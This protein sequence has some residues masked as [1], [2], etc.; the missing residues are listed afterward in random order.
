MV[1]T[2]FAKVLITAGCVVTSYIA[3]SML[4]KR[5][6]MAQ[7]H[8]RRRTVLSI[9]CAVAGVVVVWT[10]RAG[11]LGGY[12]LAGIGGLMSLRIASARLKK[13]LSEN[14]SAL[15]NSAARRES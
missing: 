15:K 5:W 7:A 8:E 3:L 12:L 14:P 11:L 4:S 6:G 9:A 10:V 13:F 2:V 1:D